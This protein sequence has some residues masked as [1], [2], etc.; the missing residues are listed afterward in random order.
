MS[1]DGLQEVSYKFSICCSGPVLKLTVSY[2]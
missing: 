2:L 1:F